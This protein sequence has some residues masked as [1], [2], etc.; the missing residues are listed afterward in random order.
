SMTRML[1]EKVVTGIPRK[2]PFP[3]LEPAMPVQLFDVLAQAFLTLALPIAPALTQGRFGLAAIGAFV[4]GSGFHV[5][6]HL[7]ES[8]GT[9]R[10]CLFVSL[11]TLC[12]Q[13]SSRTFQ[14]FAPA[15]RQLAET[16]QQP[17]VILEWRAYSVEVAHD[18]EILTKRRFPRG[19]ASTFTNMVDQS[20]TGASGP[21][22]YFHLGFVLAG[23]R[24]R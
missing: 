5:S 1:A 9:Q 19:A 18:A 22:Q 2:I 7:A 15:R 14:R 6:E 12:A 23:I 24:H 21:A 17:E 13:V 10:D 8:R 4:Q 20:Q 3:A 16:A 11:R